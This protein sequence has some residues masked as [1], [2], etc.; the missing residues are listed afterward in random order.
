MH[1]IE[2]GQLQNR[3]FYFVGI[4]GTGMA[5]L[6]ELFTLDGAVVSG[7]DV[8]DTF[9][10]QNS[11]DLRHITYSNGFNPVNVP[12]DVDAVIYSAAYSPDSHPE[13]QRARELK[14][15]LIG[16][17]EALGAYSRLY[18]SVGVSGVHGK[19]T[20]TAMLG[21]ILR[22]FG[23]PHRLLTG[24]LV[25]DF[26]NSAVLNLGGN[27]FVAETC[28]YR[29]H[30]LNF[31]AQNILLTSI[32]EDHQDYYPDLQSI[33]AA[34]LE[35]V[36]RLPRGGCL[37]YCAND[38]NVVSLV[39]NMKSF[40]SD[41][42]FKAYGI[43]DTGMDW[44]AHQIQQEKGLLR[45]KVGSLPTQFELS[46]PGKHNVAN[47]CGAL[48]MAS[49]MYLQEFQRLPSESQYQEAA[50]QLSNFKSTYRRSQ[51]LGE[52]NGVLVMDDYAH[53][54]TAIRK[55]LE[56]IKAFYQ[57][58]RLVVSFMSHT[59]SRTQAL[60]EDFAQA[61]QVADVIMFHKIYASARESNQTGIS[62]RIL[63][64]RAQKYQD[65]VYYFEEFDDAIPFLKDYLR[66]GDL[67]LTMGAGDNWK[68]AIR[69]LE[70][71]S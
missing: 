21:I 64:E 54:P 43:D 58:H 8:A 62:G 60:L 48:A 27:W 49:E 61:F 44:V 46:V 57:P 63:A 7:S 52:R 15:P 18:K 19:T 5:A 12:G 53:H 67:L 50:R 34:F 32:E 66:P 69:Y 55:T 6:A 26:G 41:L 9:F 23:F 36:S 47:A 31:S 22:A 14:L 39:Q 35:Y 33:E 28:E 25:P 30:F 37:V 17:T 59:Y 68:L 29:R 45:F 71:P 56:G 10:T 42:F 24:S 38:P 11:L 20:T 65:Q 40:R 1:T 13:L 70:D 51:V 4:K 16:Y 2:L 3:K